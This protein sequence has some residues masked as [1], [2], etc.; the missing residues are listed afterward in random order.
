MN[1]TE[2]DSKQTLEA[3][4]R[5]F[6]LGLYEEAVAGY[7]QIVDQE[8]GCA[9]AWNMLG[10][11]LQRL[12]KKEESIDALQ[13]A[14]EI[15]PRSPEIVVN[16]GN[17]YKEFGDTTKAVRNYRRA[18]SLMPEHVMA[19]ANLA[20]C[21]VELGEVEL[22]ETHA[23][24]AL[25]GDD[26]SIEAVG[27]L[28]NIAEHRRDFPAAISILEG[29][30]RQHPGNPDLLVHLGCTCMLGKRFED[31]VR[32]LNQALELRPGFVEAINNLG[33]ALFELGRLD[34]AEATLLNA[35]RLRPGMKEAY[36]NLANVQIGQRRHREALASFQ[37]VFDLDPENASAHFVCGMVH[38]VEGD[39]S[40]GWR[41]YGWR[42]RM[43]KYQRLVAAYS[44]PLWSGE[45]LDGRTLFVHAEQGIGDTLHFSRYLPLL[46]EYGGKV[47][48]EVQAPLRRLLA[49]LEGV[50][51]LLV[52][53]EPIPPMDYRVPLLNLPAIMQTDL[54][55]I[56]AAV[57]YLHMAGSAENMWRDRLNEL[58]PGLRVGLAWAGNPEHAND[59]NRSMALA[60]LAPLASIEGINWISLQKGCGR[61]QLAVVSAGLRLI[62]WTDEL[63]D[64]ADTGALIECLDLV[65]AVDT[66]VVH[67]AG[68]LNKPVWTMVPYAPDWRWM[69]DRS[70]TPWYPSMRLFRQQE[71]GNWQTVIAAVGQELSLLAKSQSSRPT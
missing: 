17:V 56:P 57:P 18:L 41:E 70:D 54:D 48:F 53:G 69:L 40:N 20:H 33:Q 19:H 4:A 71:R 39:F 6:Q 5:L 9:E 52:Q 43:E 37:R 1:K 35:L 16:L 26:R 66:S 61:E 30:V 59:R 7:R 11:V 34:E 29:A 13:N 65:L 64:F 10:I 68:A 38:L 32:V 12:G 46:K 3:A 25:S 21:L 23:R 42:W 63:E 31:A 58:A 55:S 45:N 50:D 28:A 8:R 47:I 2:V 49:T 24:Q 62:D 44:A 67:L 60:Q 36:V 15:E 22:A 27:A 51:V 14:M